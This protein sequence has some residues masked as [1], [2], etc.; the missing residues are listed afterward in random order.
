M[1]AP[2]WKPGQ[3]DDQKVRQVAPYPIAVQLL[4]AE[5]QPPLLAAIVKLT[6]IGFLMKFEGSH[7][8]KV[9]DAFHFDFE[10][11]AIHAKI[12]NIGKVIKTYDGFEN[13]G[14]GKTKVVTV[15][16][17]FKALSADQ[18]IHLENYLV[19]SGQKRR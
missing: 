16:M 13:R 3:S 2:K 9:G 1:A 18:R 6:E 14:G 17:H 4:H 7:L 5:G 10:L 19:Q 12:S 15:E 8:F 11:P